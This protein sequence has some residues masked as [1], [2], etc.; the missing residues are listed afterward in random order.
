MSTLRSTA[1]IRLRTLNFRLR[2]YLVSGLLRGPGP[3][4]AS[5][6]S[7]PPSKPVQ[8]RLREYGLQTSLIIKAKCD[9]V[10]AE[11]IIIKY[12]S[13]YLGYDFIHTLL[14][15]LQQS[16]KSLAKLLQ[17]VPYFSTVSE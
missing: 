17:T 13:N 8:P 7:K 10:K 5:S 16:A 3:R 12:S 6:T 11:K 9:V 14:R 4:M 15:T 2:L 1:A